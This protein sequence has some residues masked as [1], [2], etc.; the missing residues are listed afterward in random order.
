MVAIYVGVNG[1]EWDNL[2]WLARELDGGKSVSSSRST[3]KLPDEFL[4]VSPLKS[5][6]AGWVSAR[7]SLRCLAKHFWMQPDFSCQLHKG[8]AL[9]VGKKTRSALLPVS[10]IDS[11]PEDVSEVPWRGRTRDFFEGNGNCVQSLESHA[12]EP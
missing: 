11:A 12:E 3:T 7:H 4:P 5:V 2:S 9:L 1:F 8:I 10:D 6:V